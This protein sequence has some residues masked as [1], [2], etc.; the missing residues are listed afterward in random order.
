[1]HTCQCIHLC[2]H[3]PV[4][5]GVLSHTCTSASNRG[6]HFLLFF[7]VCLFTCTNAWFELVLVSLYSQ[8][9]SLVPHAFDVVPFC[10]SSFWVV[11]SYSP[12]FPP[13]ILYQCDRFPTSLQRGGPWLGHQDLPAK[14]AVS[15]RS[16]LVTVEAP[17]FLS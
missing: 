6:L 9:S 7:C 3:S 11:P 5:S 13:Y 16:W 15:S 14:G 1:M 10:L 8:H 12:L 17:G 2:L 4:P